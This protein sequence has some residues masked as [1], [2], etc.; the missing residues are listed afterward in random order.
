VSGVE[1]IMPRSKLM[2]YT[3]STP[4]GWFVPST[5]AGLPYYVLILNFEDV[6]SPV[7]KA[8]LRDDSILVFQIQ[9]FAIF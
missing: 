8:S 6:H 1:K 3:R 9:P 2:S 7:D 5:V 4:Q